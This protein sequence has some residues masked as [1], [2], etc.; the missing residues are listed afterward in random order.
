MNAYNDASLIVYPSG[1]KESK[2]YS[3][4]PTDGTGDLTFARASS[5][6]RVNEQGLI[7]TPSVLG[8]ELVTNGDFATN[9]DWVIGEPSTM[10]ISGG[11]AVYASTSINQRL[12]SINIPSMTVGKSYVVEYTISDYV[13][14]SIFLERP[15]NT[16]SELSS[17]NGTYKFTLVATTTSVRLR[18]F[19]ASNI[20]KIDN[21]SV[22]EVITSNIPRIDYLG[23]G[24]GSLLLE[25]QRTNLVTYSEDFSGYNKQNITLT[26]DSASSPNGTI[27]ASNIEGVGT[28]YTNLYN[29]GITITASTSYSFSIFAKKNKTNFIQILTSS[30]F[31]TQVWANF[32]LENGVVGSTG[33]NNT[34]TKI[35]SYGSGWYRCTISGVSGGTSA[36]PY[37]SPI[38]SLTASRFASFDATNH[39]IFVWGL[40]V[41]AGSYPTSYIP[42][43]GTTVTRV[44]DTSS[45]TGL[46]SVINSTEGVLFME[47]T[48]GGGSYKFITLN[49]GSSTNRV[50]IYSPNGGQISFNVRNSGGNQFNGNIF[51]DATI[52]HKIALKY[53]ANDFALWIDGVEVA[54]S[55]SGSTFAASTLTSLSLHDGGGGSV[56]QGNVQNLMVFPTALTDATLATLTT[57]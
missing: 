42:T 52:N 50:S 14:G 2:I 35:E 6:T 45:T 32:D 46:S 31:S 37:I 1:Y 55:L 40:Q 29:G 20:F 49:S 5:A 51:L 41:E 30:G 26:A 18:T 53:K 12:T 33:P 3:L 13:S 25:G 47:G 39:S 19:S 27:D 48:F 57:L 10:S 11:K 28:G 22:K 21:V 24:C 36:T 16:S 4:K 44:A 56:F 43:S 8:S 9:T 7:E 54:S 23:G 34:D 38:N 17:A 15:N